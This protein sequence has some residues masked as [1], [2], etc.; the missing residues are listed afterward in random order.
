MLRDA[1]FSDVVVRGV[2]TDSEPSSETEFVVFIA[3]TS[4]TR[5]GSLRSS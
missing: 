3:R 4:D 1:G 2:D 5:N